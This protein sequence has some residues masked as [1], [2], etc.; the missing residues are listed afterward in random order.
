MT[1]RKRQGKAAGAGAAKPTAR[2]VTYVLKLYVT[3]ATETSF[4]AISNVKNICEQYLKGQ[5]DLEITDIHQR[6]VDLR[7]DQVVAVPALVR[8]QPTPFRVMVGDFSKTDRV[9]RGL[10]L[11]VSAS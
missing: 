2:S 10:G 7:A 6:S 8:R 9:L 5:Y 1:K 11:V 3:G 4:R